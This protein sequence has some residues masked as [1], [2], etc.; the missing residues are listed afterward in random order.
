MLPSMEQELSRSLTPLT[1]GQHRLVVCDEG[2]GLP[3]DFDARCDRTSLGMR[4][5]TLLVKQLRGSMTAANR[6]DAKGACFTVTF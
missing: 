1:D 4:I 2:P 5:I 3:P 6:T